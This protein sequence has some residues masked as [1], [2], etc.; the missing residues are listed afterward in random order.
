MEVWLLISLSNLF[1]SNFGHIKN[2]KGEIL[3]RNACKRSGYILTEFKINGVRKHTSVHILVAQ[4]FIPNPD[5]K[6]YVNHIN[7]IKHDN[8][9]VNLEWVTPKENAERKIFPNYGRGS[10]RR[11][12]Q[13]SLD[14]KVIQIWN[15]INLASNTLKITGSNISTCCRGKQNTADG[16]CWMYF[17]DYVEPDL[18]E[19]W[20]EIELDSQKFRV[21]SL[22][23]VQLPSG[24]ITQGSLYAGY[25]RIGRVHK[26]RVHRLVALAFCP[27]EEGKEY[28]NHIDGDS[29]NN[30]ASNLEWC[31]QKENSQHAKRLG[32]G[33]QHAV[34]QIFNDG[35]TREFPS[36]AEAQRITGIHSSSIGRVCKELQVHAGGYRWKY[37]NATIHNKC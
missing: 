16:W 22:G 33:H 35:F 26:H 29:T 31:S 30:K 5:N 7:E 8:R 34:K 25:Y 1:V 20:R 37:I 12:I 28:M 2:N 32:L 11:I 10:S 14:G 27:K 23:K 6:P 19:E 3:R 24:I 9:A 36:L 4:A 15:S 21:S 18:D 13:K 17:E